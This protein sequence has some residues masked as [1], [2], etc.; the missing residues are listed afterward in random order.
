MASTAP[1]VASRRRFV[2]PAVALASVAALVAGAVLVDGYDARDVPPLETAVWVTRANGQYARVNTELGAIDTVRAVADPVAIVQSGSAA[3]IFSS[4]YSQAWPIDPA[5]PTDLDEGGNNGPAPSQP[6]PGTSLVSTAGAFV[7]YLTSLGEAYLSAYPAPGASQTGAWKLDP[8]ASADE[9]SEEAQRYVASA[10]ALD[11]SGRVVVYSQEEGAVRTYD[12]RRGTFTEEPESVGS[13]PIEDAVLS[14]VDGRWVLYSPASGNLW[15]QGSDEP[16]ATGTTN[17]VLQATASTGGTVLLADAAGLVSAS[18][19][20]RRAERVADAAGVPAAPVTVDGVQLAGWLSPGQASLWVGG[21]PGV[22]TLELPTGALDD[23]QNIRPAF[24][25]NGDRAVLAEASTGLVWTAPSGVLVPPIEWEPLD[26]AEELEGTVEVDDVVEQ[27][28]PVAV[29]DSF[30]VRRGATVRLPL[31]YNDHDPNGKDALSIGAGD[32]GEWDRAAFGSLALT[33]ND[34]AAVAHIAAE[35][36]SATFTYAVTDGVGS[37]APASVTVNIVPPE[38]N[39]PPEW[40]GV[41]ACVQ[42]WPAPQLTPGGFAEVSVLEG[43]VDPESDAIALVDAVP[44]D[45]NIPITVVPTA[46]GTVAL[47]HLDPNAGAGTVVIDVTVADSFGATATKTLEV[48]ITPTPALVAAPIVLAA[49][50]SDPRTVAVSDHV[51]G[52][53]GSYRLVDAVITQGEES[54][55][56]TPVISSGVIELSASAPGEYLATYT[57]E[58]AVTLAQQTATLRFTVSDSAR[59]LSLPPLTAFVRPLEDATLDVLSAVQN[60][61]SRVLLLSSAT[62]SQANLSASIVGE[63]F[64]RVSGSTETGEPGRIGVVDVVVSDGAGGTATGQVTVF[65]LAPNASAKPI[66]VPDAVSVRAGAQVDLAVLANDVSPQGERILLHPDVEGSGAEGEIA[67]ASGASVRYVAPQQPGVYSLQYTTYLENDPGR[68]D[69]T[70]ITVTVIPLGANRAPEPPVLVGRVVA[71]QTVRI[72]F[73]RAGVDPDGDEVT[74]V[75]VAPL[76]TGSGVATVSAAGGAVLYTAPAAGVPGGQVTFSYT[77]RDARGEKGEGTVRVGVLVGELA[78]VAPITY[79]D[80][81]NAQKDSRAPVTV[82]PLDNDRDPLRGTLRLVDIKPNA[83]PGSAEYARLEAL[84]DSTT[85]LEDGTVVL[86]GGDAAGTQSYVYTVESSSSLST[87]EGL[88]VVGVSEDLGPSQLVVSDTTVTARTRLDLEDGIDVVTGKVR[89]STGDPSG[90]KL[91][92]WGPLANVYSVEGWTISGPTGRERVLVPFSLEGTDF[93]GNEVQTFGF[94]RIPAFDD[95]RLQAVPDLTPIQ[96]GEEESVAIGVGSSV[97]VAPGDEVELRQEIPFAVQRSNARCAPSGADRATY[98]A[99]R[100][101]PWSDSCSLAVRLPGQETWSIVGVPIAIAPKDPQAILNPT[102]RTI[103]PG[104]TDTVVITEAMVTWEGGR[105]GDLAGMEF[106][107]SYAGSAFLVSTSDGVVSIQAVAGAAPGTR[108][109]IEVSSPDYGGLT[110]VISLVVGAAR[111][112]VP[113][114]ATFTSQCDVSRGN[115]CT[116][117]AVGLPGEYDPFAGIEGGGLTIANVGTSGAVSCPVATVTKS[118]PTTLVASWPSSPRPVGGECTVPF[119]VADAQGRLGPAQLTLDVLGYPQTPAS[120]TTVDYTGNSVTLQVALGT[121]VDAHPSVTSV[122]IFRSGTLVPATCAVSGPGRYRCTIT[123]LVNGERALYTARAVNSVGESLDTSA[124]ETWAYQPPTIS[125]LT[126]STVYVP[127]TTS[128]GTGAVTAS[129]ES[130][131]DTLSF[132]VV[133]T[134]ANFSRTGPVTTFTTGLPVGPQVLQVT[135]ISKF[136]PPIPGGNAGATSSFAVTVVGSPYYTGTTSATPS[137]TSITVDGVTLNANYSSDALTQEWGAW[138]S[139]GPTPTCSM[140]GSGEAVLS[141]VGITTS[142]TNVINGLNPNTTY[143]VVVCGSNHFGASASPIASAFTWVPPGAPTGDLTYGIGDVPVQAGNAYTFV[144]NDDPNPDALTGFELY[145]WYAG[146]GKTTTFDPGFVAGIDIT[147]AYCWTLDSSL[148]GTTADI[149]PTS[150]SPS[151]KVI[152]QFPDEC[153]ILPQESDVVVTGVDSSGYAVDISSGTDYVV[154]W[155]AAPYS[156]FAS[157]THPI[158]LCP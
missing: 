104:A 65:L 112:D 57:V 136:T 97:D 155:T 83:S 94:L 44:R 7:A 99:G 105:V 133:Q 4:G 151:N 66:A 12:A 70:Q 100:E 111:P 118:S 128:Q 115:S 157:I 31:L 114:G 113:R 158:T 119:T 61:T 77:V 50:V 127:G 132:T 20:E 86:R 79:S 108:E 141:G 92:V 67:F 102:S 116:I 54:F 52:G 69:T 48:Q 103:S 24:H 49:G 62:S 138:V 38:Q 106:T 16:I 55:A 126:A 147:A 56:V 134:G 143:S 150:G 74:L 15:S 90:L 35:S 17:A 149:D 139:G 27:E 140:N 34:Q 22:R 145:Y 110:A 29:A 26:E 122:A 45:L 3:M 39:G 98:Q 123:G 144:V 11:A 14:L 59:A 107:A 42:T 117:T 87:A 89:W 76:P 72:P 21:G 96:V 85:S 5:Y 2:W 88:I 53:S 51:S 154:T 109:R 28:P 124:H 25:S 81:V 152:V 8:F 30:G 41:E 131:D 68:F 156:S 32:V 64:L 101:A 1:P 78:D 58:D 19:A 75:E 120:V 40:C 71:G 148:C 18:I 95:M 47:R 33:D 36:G 63:T 93:A 121:A 135:P 46:D 137:G 37:S 130:S 43:W 125:S 80:Y 91:S 142:S 84:I 82:T 23:V 13:A 6:P 146:A 129:V 10:M 73:A 153:V 60:T 9:G